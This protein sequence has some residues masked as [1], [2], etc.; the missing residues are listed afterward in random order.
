MDV[1]EALAAAH[2]HEQ[3]VAQVVVER[4]DVASVAKPHGA[5]GLLQWPTVRERHKRIKL[6]LGYQRV[7][8]RRPRVAALAALLGGLLR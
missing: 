4:R 7:R 6:K 3:A 1:R 5:V 2:L 8:Q